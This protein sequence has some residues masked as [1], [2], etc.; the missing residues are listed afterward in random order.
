MGYLCESCGEIGNSEVIF[1]CG[2]CG[3]GGVRPGGDKYVCPECGELGIEGLSQTCRKCG[4]VV[5]VI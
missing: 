5:E 4:N 2:Q 1:T 3:H